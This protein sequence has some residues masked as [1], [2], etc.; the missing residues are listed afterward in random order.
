MTKILVAAVC[1]NS[2]S[3]SPVWKDYCAPIE[4]E[5]SL[6]R[7]VK[8]YLLVCL[9]ACCILCWKTSKCVCSAHVGSSQ[10]Q[11]VRQSDLNTGCIRPWPRRVQLSNFSSFFYGSVSCFARR[12]C[13]S[14]LHH[15]LSR[16][17][18]WKASG[19]ITCRFWSEV[20]N[21]EAIYITI[22]CYPCFSKTKGLSICCPC[23]PPWRCQFLRFRSA[24]L[25]RT[26]QKVTSWFLR[27]L[28]WQVAIAIDHNA[29][30]KEFGISW[31]WNCI[32]S[33]LRTKKAVFC[34]VWINWSW[35]GDALQ[36]F[37]C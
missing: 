23:F 6:G 18:F 28:A 9:P 15:S 3:P 26:Y 19:F 22:Q 37:S 16:A 12:Q 25:C 36:F 21:H 13:G 35:N 14:F 7:I 10:T 29:T 1:H 8:G 5:C 33:F 32:S 27:R 30:A 11:T 20:S 34:L 2:P 17:F 24:R 4:I 31:I